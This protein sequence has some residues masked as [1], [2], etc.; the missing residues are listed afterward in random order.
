MS[1]WFSNFNASEALAGKLS[2]ISST[3]QKVSSKVQQSL[4]L[5]DDLVKKLTL[6]SDELLAEHN[7]IDAEERRKE[8]VRDYLSS[9]LPWETKDE[10]REILVEECREAIQNMASKGDT[11]TGPFSLPDDVKRMF[12]EDSDM[13]EASD[14]S[15][16][17][18]DKKL[19]KMGKLPPL[20]EDFDLDAHVGLIERL[21]KVDKNLVKSH[22]CLQ[23]A[24][25]AEKIFW[26]NY[27]FH[28]A[29]IRYEKGL[30]VEEIWVETGSKPSIEQDASGTH[31]QT[32]IANEES[33]VELTFEA[34][35]KDDNDDDAEIESVLNEV[36]DHAKSD[37][38]ETT[39]STKSATNEYEMINEVQDKIEGDDL[40]DLD[41]EIARELA[42]LEDI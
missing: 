35:D 15:I 23:N 21:F 34:D 28:C 33:S 32:Q 42:E 40:D 41:A 13:E 7:L 29:Y 38:V 31:S 1:S 20:L 36:T 30:S 24:G 11:F 26:K 8:A 9:L 17:E 22:S 19:Q 12:A 16:A 14:E 25:K 4:P 2:E 3:V 5:D 39:S 10:A 18:A 37:T 27:F 6:R